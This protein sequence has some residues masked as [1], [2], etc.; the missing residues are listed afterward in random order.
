MCIPLGM[1]IYVYYDKNENLF[2][3][4]D[5]DIDYDY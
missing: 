1:T 5:E 2:E 4:E 3:A